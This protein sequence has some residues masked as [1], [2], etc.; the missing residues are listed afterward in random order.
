MRTASYRRPEHFLRVW[1]ILLTCI[2]GMSAPVSAARRP[3]AYNRPPSA[4]IPLDE[5]YSRISALQNRIDSLTAVRAQLRQ[6]SARGAAESSLQGSLLSKKI[7]E[8]NEAIAKKKA[9][10]ADVQARYEKQRQDSAAAVARSK[11]QVDGVRKEIAR[12]D[13]EIVA[14]SNDLAVLS[15]RREQ[16]ALPAGADERAITQ[17][18]TQAAR[19]DSIIRLRQTDL[20]NLAARRSKFRQ[21]SLDV[22]TRRL[23]DRNRFRSQMYPFDSLIALCDAAIRQAEQKVAG[24]QA[25]KEKKLSLIK[26]NYELMARQKKGFEERIGR[27]NAEITT[28]LAERQRLA[29]TAGAAQQRYEQLRAPYDGALNEAMNELQRL[30]RDKPLLQTLRQKLRIDSA[31]AKTRDALDKAIQLSAGNKKGGKK[32][33]EQ[34]E[35]ELDSLQALEEML[36]RGTPGLRQRESQTRG[37][38]VSQKAALTDSTLASIDKK[39]AFAT[40]QL[41]KARRGLEDFDRKNPPVRNA[42]GQR[43]AQLDTLIA[44]KKKEGIQMTDWSDSL[45]MAM[46]D[47]QNAIAGFAAAKRT[48]S[49]DV[50][51]FINAKK[52]EKA[53][54][55]AKRAKI[56]RDSLQNDAAAMEALRRIKNDDAALADQVTRLQ[57]EI[58]RT[59]AERDK[60][61]QS[62][63]SAIEKNRQATTAALA[64]KKKNEN[65]VTAKQ[66]GITNLSLQSD[67]LR[68]DSVALIKNLDQQV[69][70]LSPAL[71]SLA[72]TLSDYG[73]EIGALE[74]Q[75]DSLRRLASATHERSSDGARTVAQQIAAVNRSIENAQGDIAALNAQKKEAYARLES[76]K[77][78]YDSL[79]TL[80]EHERDALV[81]QRDKVRQDSITAENDLRRSVQKAASSL[82]E[83]DSTI[84]VREKEVADASAE[85]NRA[86]DDS[87]KTAAA[88]ST[89]SQTSRGMDSLLAAKE[90]EI[91][92]LQQRRDKA[93]QDSVKEIKHLS[94]LLAA[95]HNEVLK[96]SIA[97]EQRKNEFALSTAVTGAPKDDPL[98][99][100]YEEAVKAATAEVQAQNA[101]IKKKKS[102]IARLKA[103]RDALTSASSDT[104]NSGQNSKLD[105]DKL[106]YDSL[107]AIA[108]Q[109]LTAIVARRDI[110]RQDSAS[111]ENNLR[112]S[113]PQE[114]PSGGDNTGA[115]LQKE[116]ADATAAYNNAREDSVKIANAIPNTM[117]P[118]GQAIRTIDAVLGVKTKEL[119]GFHDQQ[120][121]ARQDGL[122]ESK[123]YADLL[124]AAHNEI[125]KKSIAL[126]QK[127]NDLALA[128]AAKNS[129]QTNADP[130][131]RNFKQALDAAVLELHAQN[132]LLDN[133][134]AELARLQNV[135]DAIDAKIRT[136]DQGGAATARPSA[137]SPRDSAQKCSE[138]IY[139]LVGENRI[140]EATA[141]F[142]QSQSFL[143]ANMD[144]ESFQALRMTI[145]EMGG[146][147]K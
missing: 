78:F 7:A 139:V 47:A 108:S 12:L 110:A 40:V 141:I 129:A 99:R 147:I 44:Q 81:A 62:L 72:G 138:N 51:K 30:T 52:D 100:S 131:Q 120:D 90:K 3:A 35:T 121:K 87:I 74:A 34:R 146:T 145:T 103:V 142:L 21:D 14:Q 31:I 84:A 49:P 135:R 15:G 82:R 42:A 133:K 83:Y 29:Q 124:A 76:D 140:D 98:L 119:A 37:L 59:A 86:R 61:K 8:I 112:T 64:D 5:V 143:K 24:D 36:L 69:A 10:A 58:D 41:D 45:N 66:Q 106:Y 53:G 11:E 54:L 28:Y 125:N 118:Y 97:L 48:G 26:E 6:D 25:E 23:G 111:A 57:S 32:L 22:E 102:D 38:T 132:E 4:S 33:V 16:P 109:E 19:Y 92:D 105:R 114:A 65:L 104:E 1:L 134:K 2:G 107:L 70:A 63:A 94:D 56:Q 144:Q 96:R 79:I 43:I 128:T 13:A 9:S 85:L 67:K 39:I 122:Q 137:L 130:S 80:A 17:M 55:A 77:R 127:R 113:A 46:Q 93:V 116:I 88:R 123:R 95:V 60:T 75:S 117:Q 27:A 20:S 89:G 50:D 73:R 126:E 18:Q 91:E 136:R 101:I 115:S 68:Q 71:R